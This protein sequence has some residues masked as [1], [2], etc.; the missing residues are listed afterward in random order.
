LMPAEVGSGP[1][2]LC[3]W[4]PSHIPHEPS[5][6]HPAAFGTAF[7]LSTDCNLCNPARL[8]AGAPM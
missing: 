7:S 8:S 6:C 3:E 4:V 1:R 5:S 2:W